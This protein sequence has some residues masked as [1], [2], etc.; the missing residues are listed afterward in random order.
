MTVI[1]K[2]TG[3]R[4]QQIA[5]KRPS[6]H[7]ARLFDSLP[8]SVTELK[9]TQKRRPPIIMASNRI[10]IDVIK[11]FRPTG[12]QPDQERDLIGK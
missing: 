11:A 4:E 7:R 1:P 10:T 2:Q 5:Q 6:Q 8:D 9:A 3:S 12:L